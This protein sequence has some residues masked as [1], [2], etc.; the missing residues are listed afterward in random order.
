M[1][2]T[3]LSEIHVYPVKSLAG[4]ALERCA[5]EPM[6]LRHDRRWM[7][8]DRGGNFLTQRTLPQMALVQPKLAGDRLTLSTFGMEDHE[9]PHAQ[10]PVMEVRIWKDTVRALHVDEETDRWLSQA[11]GETCRLVWFPAEAVRRCDPAY[12]GPSDHTG[13][14]DGFPLLLVSEAS[15]E[16]LNRRLERPVEMR[17]FRPNLV[18]RG[19][20][21]YAED[22][23]RRIRIGDIGIRLVKPCS[24][25]P[26]PTVDPETGTFAGPEPLKTLATYR[27]RNG[28]VFF[29]QNAVPE[30]EGTVRLGDCVTILSRGS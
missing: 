22:T 26:V 5:L 9:V 16:D 27:E 30:G 19:C 23:W 13:F 11:I 12:A 2:G 6:G 25:C 8:V 3:V 18:V 1:N 20:E 4:I 28:K 24:R 15:L 10:G 17:R 7:V 21:P 14:A 29:G